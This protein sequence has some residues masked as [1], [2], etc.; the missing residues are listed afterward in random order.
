MTPRSLARA[1]FRRL[2][3]VSRLLAQHEALIK[4]TGYAPPGHFYSPLVSLADLEKDAAKL[5]GSVPPTIAGID[6]NESEQLKLLGEFEQYYPSIPFAP[7]KREGSRYHFENPSYRYSDAIVLHCML[8]HLKPQRLIEIGSGF[9]SCATLDTNEVFFGNSIETT[10]IEP[11]PE[12]LISLIS[13]ED[14]HRVKLIPKRL[15]DVDSGIFEQLQAND[16]LF[17]DST[18][19]SKLGSD[20]NRILFEILPML[21]P[22]VHIHIH[23][24][25]Y[26][27]EYPKEWFLAGRS[28]NEAY[29]LRAFLQYNEKFRIAFMNTYMEHFH[30]ERFRENMPLCLKDRGGSIWLRKE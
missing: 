16:I 14:K 5:F 7:Q 30:E 22:G 4:A 29:L 15:Q 1:I 20:V 3:P 12:L 2:P 21:Q 13:A 26:P 11:N 28:W 8:R 25:F 23:D 6:L 9:S 10:F 27:F 18:H 19:V 17:V 24:V